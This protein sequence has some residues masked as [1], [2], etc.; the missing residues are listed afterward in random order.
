[1][2][3]VGRTLRAALV[4]SVVTSVV[5][6]GLTVA[7]SVTATAASTPGS[8][9]VGSTSYSVPSGAV[10]AVAGGGTGGSGTSS[11][12][13]QSA[14]TAVSKAPSGATVVL[15][16][17]TYRES[18]TVPSGKRL[19]IQSYP[20]EA[21]WFDGSRPVTGWTASGSTWVASGWT[22][23]WD[24]KVSLTPGADE[25]SRY[26]DSA[27]PMAGA[28]EGVW[29]NG[30]ELTQVGSASAVTAGK[31]YVDRT[32]KRLVIGTDPAGKTVEATTSLTKAIRVQG[33]GT[34][35][36][37]IGVRRYATP[38]SGHGAI[39]YEVNDVTFENVVVKDNA[40]IGFFGWGDRATFRNVTVTG[41]GILGLH[42]DSAPGL[43]IV[44]SLFDNNNDQ[45]FKAQPISS[46][47]KITGADG[48]RITD[49]TFSSNYTT[50]LW[51]DGSMRNVTVARNRITDNGA[52]GLTYEI[53]G[54]AVI[55][56]NYVARNREGLVLFNANDID[57]WNNT[58]DRNTRSLQFLQDSRRQPN[59][60]LASTVPWVSG[61]IEVHN[62][63]IAY[64]TNTCPLLSQDLSGKMYGS[65]FDIGSN[66]N[67]FHRTSSTSPSRFGCWANGTAGTKSF[68]TLS[69]W[70][71]GTS[72]D[73]ASKLFEGTGILTSTGALTS[74]ASSSS[75]SVPRSLPSNV[76]TAI[77]RTA[78]DRS[79][80]AWIVR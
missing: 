64:G 45:R 8:A 30:S 34:T 56:D 67:V 66:G 50:G 75:T 9:S 61:D 58:F 62:N 11:S 80:G 44:S 33:T 5:A 69:A 59:S 3:V 68:T 16:G 54:H 36:R 41:N 55:A 19:T 1:M 39:S 35:I 53:S 10:Y 51:F 4:T 24:G 12:P 29:V 70:V 32:Y 57:V 71:S 31:F 15:R 79:L 65:Q 38:L 21:V 78:G 13:Y 42:A 14:Q 20:G 25:R 74:T 27:Y 63:A 2:S 48:A 7:S 18:L 46:G 60:S 22:S 17:G 52:A 77:G 73:A 49:S 76:A 40:T 47:A 26:V 6:A 72:N 28:P 43:T 37:G 23:S